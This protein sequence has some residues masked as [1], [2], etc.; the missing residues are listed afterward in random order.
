MVEIAI[1]GSVFGE[2]KNSSDASLIEAYLAK[3]N[4]D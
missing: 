3:M 1:P 2:F 4:W